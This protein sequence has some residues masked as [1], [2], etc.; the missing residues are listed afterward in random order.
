LCTPGPKSAQLGPLPPPDFPVRPIPRT[1][2]DVRMT[3]GPYLPGLRFN[4]EYASHLL[5]TLRAHSSVRATRARAVRMSHGLVGQ[6]RQLQC[7]NHQRTCR[8]RFYHRLGLAPTDLARWGDKSST[9]GTSDH[10]RDLLLFPAFLH[11]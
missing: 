3:S 2:R 5:T 6:G 9:A 10:L 11:A 8:C 1:I 4:A 7:H